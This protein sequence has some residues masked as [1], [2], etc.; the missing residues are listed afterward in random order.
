MFGGLKIKVSDDGEMFS[1]DKTTV[2]S[3]GR[4]DNRK[5]KQLKPVINRYGYK[6]VTL[7]SKGERKTYLVHQLVAR[8]FIPNPENKETVNHINGNK[9]DN[10]ISN[11]EWATS[12]E[13]KDHAIRNGLCIKNIEALETANKNKSIKTLY[14]GKIY[15]SIN[16]A[17][18][19]TGD[20]WRVIKREGVII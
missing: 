18:Q 4:L 6:Q 11:L 19:E 2:R 7:S 3:N 8:T 15:D 17:C 13:Q 1:L 9:L 20:H 12:K 14:K 5:G 10:H 16:Q